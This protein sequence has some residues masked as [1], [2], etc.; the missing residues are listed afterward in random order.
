MFTGVYCVFYTLVSL[1]LAA[2]ATGMGEGSGIS[3]LVMGSPLSAID[4]PLFPLPGLILGAL[5]IFRQRR[6][7]AFWLL[8]HYVGI[9]I[10]IW[11]APFVD[12]SLEQLHRTAGGTVAFAIFYL[13]GN[14]FAWMVILRRDS[15]AVPV[16][17]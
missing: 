14:V 8:I 5:L 9:P 11:R 7:A 3:L 12:Y 16:E 15:V 4:V 13:L 2:A 10:A 6:V 17:G 1:V